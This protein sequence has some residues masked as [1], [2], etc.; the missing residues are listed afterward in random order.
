MLKNI[1]AVNDTDESLKSKASGKFG[2]NQGFI[3]KFEFIT[4]GGINNGPANAVDIWFKVDEKEYRRRLYEDTGAL[5]GKNNIKVYPGEVG[6]EDLYFDSMSQKI[7]VIKHCLK[8]VGVTQTQ[9]DAVVAT[10]NPADIVAGIKSLVVLV[11]AD[12]ATKPVDIFLEY[13]WQ[14]SEGQDKTYLQIPKTMG[15]GYFTC[16]AQVG[17]WLEKKAEDGSLTYVNQNG[18]VHPIMKDKKFMEGFK[19][20]QQ[21]EGKEASNNILAQAANMQPGNGAAQKS[22]W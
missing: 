16:A 17:I 14:I 1:F 4:D 2:L 15:G 11:P 20:N 6:Y 7:A 5:F 8:A 21:I 10:I 19:A 18:Q 3:S 22:T 12:F 13:Q 9:I